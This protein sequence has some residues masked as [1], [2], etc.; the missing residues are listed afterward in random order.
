ML[1]HFDDDATLAA[2]EQARGIHTAARFFEQEPEK[3]RTVAEY[4]RAGAMSAAEIAR[5][6]RCSRNT[7]AAVRRQLIAA[8]AV[9]VEQLNRGS[10]AAWADVQHQSLDRIRE[11][12][13]DD[14]QRAKV[15]A[16]DAA[17]IAGISAEKLALAIGQ[18]T[19]RVEVVGGDLAELE[20]A[21]D[22]ECVATHLP[23]ET[24][25]QK[26]AA[27]GGEVDQAGGD[28]FTDEEVARLAAG[29]N[30]EGTTDA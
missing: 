15:S 24:L 2:S 5:V 18:P 14:E 27:D 1:P 9:S 28:A 26:G 13:A 11:I 7:V 30:H 16:K 21:I 4:I 20:R 22:A 10:A 29:A 19:A 12:Y 17:I 23:A 3:A 6:C 8:G 25:G